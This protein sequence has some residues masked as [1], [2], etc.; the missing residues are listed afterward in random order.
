MEAKKQGDGAEELSMEE[1]LQSIRSIIANDE[2][3][4]KVIEPNTFQSNKESDVLELTDMIEDDGSIT[5]L[6]AKSEMIDNSSIDDVLNNIDFALAPEKI[7]EP[8]IELIAEE[9]IIKPIVDNIDS[10]L[11]K[12]AENATLS[13]FSKIKNANHTTTSE[14]HD[15]PAFRSGTTIEDLVEEMLRPMMKQ[16]LDNNLPEIVERIVER[17][18]VRLARR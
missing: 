3:T 6:K 17:E 13:A 11:S 15:S 5:D 12:N 8:E 14:H 1:I 10:L 16:W 9:T 4:V 7:L 2:E 18:V